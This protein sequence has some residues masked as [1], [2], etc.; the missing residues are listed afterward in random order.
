M[1]ENLKI[2]AAVK[3]LRVNNEN[4]TGNIF[5]TEALPSARGIPLTEDFLNEAG[6]RF[7][8]FESAARAYSRLNK[9]QVVDIK[10]GPSCGQVS[11]Q[12]PI[13]PRNQLAHFTKKG[14]STVRTIQ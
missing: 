8:P 7:L 3:V 9:H 13:K 14:Q 12:K 10:T 11:Q 2:G 5:I 4:M 1:Y 6:D